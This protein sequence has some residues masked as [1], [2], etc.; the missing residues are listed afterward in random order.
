MAA[1]KLLAKASSSIALAHCFSSR[2]LA[3]LDG[4]P[5]RRTATMS[6]QT[7]RSLTEAK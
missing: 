3:Q 4:W 2:R 6:R 1:V 5:V 7:G